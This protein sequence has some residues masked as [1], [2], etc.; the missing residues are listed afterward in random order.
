MRSISPRHAAVP[1][2]SPR[3]ATRRARTRLISA[4]VFLAI[5]RRDVYVTGREL[6]VFL[7]Q[8]GLQPLFLLFVFGKLLTQLGFARPGYATLLFPGTIAITAVL[9]GIQ[10]IALPL[11][12]EFSYTR[13]VEDRLQAPLPTQLVAIEKLLFATLR[14]LLASGIMFLLGFLLL[15]IAPPPGKVPLIAAVVLLAA[16]TGSAGGLVFGTLVPPNRIGLGFGLVLTPLIFTGCGQYP[17]AS[18]VRLPWFQAATLLNPLTYAS[19]G[20]RGLL[21][22]PV[23]HMATWVCLLALTGASAGL[24]SLG[25]WGFLRRALG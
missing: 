8:V 17:W 23:P 6:P 7:A 24:G 13:E 22:P 15:H 19:E 9:T 16:L 21:D 2:I 1:S 18:L 14:A 3:H 11:A 12:Q 5:L 20:M 10:G 4:Q 25:V